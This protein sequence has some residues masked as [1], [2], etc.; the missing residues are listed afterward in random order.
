MAIETAFL[1]LIG[2]R[3]REFVTV[4]LAMNAATNL[5]INLILQNTGILVWIVILLEIL[6][7]GV[8]YAVYSLMQKPS[9]VLLMHTAIANLLS[10][11]VGGLLIR[12]LF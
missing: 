10:I 8:E 4:C 6:A 11:S 7:V 5:T 9:K 3:G 2:Y 1:L 12:L